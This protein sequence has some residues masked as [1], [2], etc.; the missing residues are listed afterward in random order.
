MLQ[1]IAQ[2]DFPEYSGRGGTVTREADREQN[3]D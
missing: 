1:K 2:I 3:D